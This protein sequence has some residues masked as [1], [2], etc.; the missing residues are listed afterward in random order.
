MKL[1]SS[2]DTCAPAS[3]NP[4]RPGRRPRDLR[5]MTCHCAANLRMEKKGILRF[6]HCRHEYY[7]K[8]LFNLGDPPTECRVAFCPA[9]DYKTRTWDLYYHGGLCPNCYHTKLIDDEEQELLA[10]EAAAAAA[11]QPSN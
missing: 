9:C 4:G 6:N 8:T 1:R 5:W 11:A 2:L 3:A 10:E 7:D